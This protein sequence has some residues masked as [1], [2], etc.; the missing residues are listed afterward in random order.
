MTARIAICM[1]TFNP[2]RKLLEVQLDSIRNQLG[3]DWVCFISD[4]ASGPAGIADLE[5]AIDGDSRFLLSRSP[6]RLGF[7][8]NFERALEMV[9]A[10]EGFEFVALCDQ[11]DRWYPEKLARLRGELGGAQLVYSDQRVVT[12]EGEVISPTYWTDRRNNHTDLTSLLIANTVT[13]AASLFRR[14]LLDLA[15]P[16]PAVAGDQYHDHWLGL[17]ALSVGDIAYVDE[18]LY[19]YVQHQR[20]VLGHD[21]ANAGSLGRPIARRL[22]PRQFRQ[23]VNG[24]ASAYFDVYLRLQ[25]LAQALISRCGDRMP[26]KKRRALER[27]IATA[28][29]PLGPVRLWLRSLRSLVGRNETFGVERVLAR[30]VLYRHLAAVKNRLPAQLVDRVSAEPGDPRPG[31]LAGVVEADRMGHKIQPLAASI[32]AGVPERINLLIPSIDL[33]HFFG[34]YI[35]KFNLAKKLADDGHRV[36]I[37][38][39]DPNRSLPGDWREQISGYAGL[40]GVFDQIEVEFGRDGPTLL[41]VNPRDRFIA[42]TWWTAHIAER[43]VAQTERHR[44]LYLI[45][46]Y[47][48][49]TVPPG[50]WAALAQDSYR[51]PHN[52]LFSTDILRAFFREREYGVF[53]GP[54]GDADSA[55]FQ[56]AIT[57]VSPPD[58]RELT[59]RTRRRLLFYARPESHAARNMFELGLLALRRASA[60]GIFDSTWSLHGIGSIGQANS[61]PLSRSH[62][63]ELSRR[64]SQDGYGEM[65]ARNDIGLALMYAPHPSLVPIE[66]ASAGMIT[67]TNTFETKTAEAM[68][69]ISPNLRTVEPNVTELVETLRVAVEQTARGED[70][71]RGASV[72]WSRAWDES[73][74]AECLKQIQ[75]LLDRC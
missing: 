66:M 19:D 61:V 39:V 17:V 63:L 56:N 23:T 65:L 26:A 14:S 47:E 69:A 62:S 49:L 22:D 64:Q 55:S 34:G 32:E 43:L 5:A 27:F 16:F 50:S 33:D 53:A 18:P 57:A 7:Y 70:R 3:V 73:F 60:E 42:T 38:T 6:E 45:Q 71:V 41:E 68:A 54:E 21:E 10:D 58:A 24:W 44:F 75:E 30:A 8:H 48:P 31:E 15:L 20:A 72:V 25:A 28:R 35:A 74:D 4:D 67:I 52:A 36:R 9:P 51:L 59:E 2:S 29:D 40:A 13:G 11:D 1:A 12:E 46:E 37:I